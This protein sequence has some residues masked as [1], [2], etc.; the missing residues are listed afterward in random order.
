MEFS[1]CCRPAD[2]SETGKGTRAASALVWSGHSCP[3]FLTLTLTLILTLHEHPRT[4]AA[5][6]WK[7]GASAPR[8]A[9]L[10]GSGFSR[11]STVQSPCH[12]EQSMRIRL[13]NPHAQSKDPCTPIGR[14]LVSGSS[15]R[16]APRRSRKPGRARVPLVP[17]Q[18][19]IKSAA[20]AAEVHAESRSKGERQPGH[21]LTGKNSSRGSEHSRRL[22][23]LKF[24]AA[25]FEV[26]L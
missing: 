8:Q 14:Q 17:H 20:S 6:S 24:D 18:C 13:S 9:Q 19:P 2:E 21:S 3:L 1:P 10:L 22:I 15:P 25:P 26:F 23:M 16:V 12:P 7:S 5:T 11:R 4:L